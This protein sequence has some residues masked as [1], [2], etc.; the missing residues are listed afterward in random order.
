MRDLRTTINHGSVSCLKP[1][2]AREP[3]REQ[4]LRAQA[5]CSA[6]KPSSIQTR[7]KHRHQHQLP[8]LPPT[9][10]EPH[11]ACTL[12]RGA[13]RAWRKNPGLHIFRQ[14]VYFGSTLDF[15][16]RVCRGACL[17]MPG[18]QRPAQAGSVQVG[19]GTQPPW[20]Y[21]RIIASDVSPLGSAWACSPSF[22]W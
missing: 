15:L 1:F 16:P 20:L 22:C 13:T 9:T 8:A 12:S 17:D 19:W 6:S 3:A 5:G 21:L 14:P 18:W 2:N 11:T 10:R 4:H 7:G